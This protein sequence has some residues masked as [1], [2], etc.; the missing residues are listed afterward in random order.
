M[1]EASGTL[2][3]QTW[4]CQISIRSVCVNVA[5]AI[6]ASVYV[7]DLLIVKFRGQHQ[8]IHFRLVRFLLSSSTETLDNDGVEGRSIG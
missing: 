4:S 8:Q 6:I 2:V 3:D 7:V 5:L 1:K